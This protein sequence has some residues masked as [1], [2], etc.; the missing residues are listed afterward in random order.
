MLFQTKK[1]LEEFKDKVDAG[2][3]KKIEEQMKALEESRKSGEPE[4]IN[5]KIEA[6]NKVVQ[7]IGA[8]IYQEAAAKQSAKSSDKQGAE[9]SADDDVVDAEFTEKKEK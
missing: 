3:K 6:L 7:E 9:K 1:V 2:T 8:K 4:E 5:A